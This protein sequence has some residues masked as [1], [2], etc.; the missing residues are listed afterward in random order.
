MI[1]LRVLGTLD[2]RDREHGAVVGSVLAQPKRIALLCYLALA[3]SRGAHSRKR[4]LALFWPDSDDERARNSLNQSVFQL[5][6]SLGE[7]TLAGTAEDVALRDGAI[8]CDA[9]EFDAA[10][11]ARDTDRA[12]ELYGGELLPGFHVDGCPEFEHWL[13]G[14]RERLRRRA[15]A[16]ALDAAAA[17]EN[18]GNGVAA[19]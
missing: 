8:W 16:A 5:R 1:E 18:T 3:G 14:E 9:V 17:L 19:L 10:L 4:L 15:V 7:A 11:A 12:L 13:D 2:L 6:R